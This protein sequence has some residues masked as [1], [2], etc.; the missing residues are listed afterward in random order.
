MRQGVRRLPPIDFAGRFAFN[1]VRARQRAYM[2]QEALAER[3]SLHRTA[4]GKLELAE[5]VPRIDTLVKLYGALEVPAAT[6]LDGIVWRPG[7]REAGEF[8][9]GAGATAGSGRLIEPK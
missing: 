7:H 2:S 4:V 5:R 9:L 8:E 3:A 6:L 1:L